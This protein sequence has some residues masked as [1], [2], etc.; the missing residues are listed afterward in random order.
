MIPTCKCS[1]S[2]FRVVIAGSF[3]VGNFTT[4]LHTTRPSI[5][6]DCITWG[7][8][9]VRGRASATSTHRCPLAWLVYSRNLPDRVSWA[10]KLILSR[11]C[12]QSEFLFSQCFVLCLHSHA[13]AKPC[14][15][16]CSAHCAQIPHWILFLCKNVCADA[17]RSRYGNRAVLPSASR[18]QVGPVSARADT[19]V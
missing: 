9:G 7:H 14:C 15:Y 4:L 8:Q 17:Q 2:S 18:V 13:M 5:L 1:F 6:A 10:K 19:I 11:T 3:H 16:S 12:R